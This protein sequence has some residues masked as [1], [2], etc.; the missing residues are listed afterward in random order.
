MPSS[1]ALMIL[2]TMTLAATGPRALADDLFAS[3]VAPVLESRCLKCHGK[4]THIT[5]SLSS[6]AGSM[7]LEITDN[8]TGF[9]LAA[10]RQP[11][12]GLDNLASRA[13]SFGG[14]FQIVSQPGG[15]T[16]VQAEFPL[17]KGETLIDPA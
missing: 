17:L 3:K 5:I 14:R 11:N 8:G 1:L 16:V 6:A 12:H 13:T 2:G 15:P 10:V 4:A 7:R 9:N